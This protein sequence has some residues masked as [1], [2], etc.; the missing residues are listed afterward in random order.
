[1][2]PTLLALI[3][4][5]FLLLTRFLF[6]QLITK[7]KKAKNDHEKRKL[8]CEIIRP[9]NVCKPMQLKCNKKV[10]LIECWKSGLD[11]RSQFQAFA[12]L[13]S[14]MTSLDPGVRCIWLYFELIT[15]FFAQHFLTS[16]LLSRA[17]PKSP[18]LC[19]DK[20]VGGT[21]LLGLMTS[22]HFLKTRKLETENVHL[23]QIFSIRLVILFYC[24]LSALVCRH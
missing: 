20:L 10:L 5:T 23:N 6:F 22:C 7:S 3:L 4:D 8:H 16:K 21:K 17:F 24:I 15:P 14:D 19:K 12:F 13:K 1:M 2:K 18:I 11:A 9:P